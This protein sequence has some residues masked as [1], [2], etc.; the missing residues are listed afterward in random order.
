MKMIKAQKKK[1]QKTPKMYTYTDVSFL[2]SEL[3]PL[4]REVNALQT[5]EIGRKSRL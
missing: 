5:L 1:Q 4:T 2:Y 3:A